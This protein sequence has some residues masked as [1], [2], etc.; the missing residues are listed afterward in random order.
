MGKS[1]WIQVTGQEL[2]QGEVLN[3]CLVPVF[4]PDFGDHAS[5]EVPVSDADLI[6]VTQTAILLIKRSAWL[7]YVR[8]IRCN[9]LK[10]ATQN[11]QRRDGGRKF[12]KAGSKDY[13]CWARLTTRTTI[14]ALLR[15]ILAK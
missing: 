9:G 11:S 15:S 14:E 6:I 8:S 4:S 7:P 3:N 10:S 1:F 13:I 5:E 12:G 2:A